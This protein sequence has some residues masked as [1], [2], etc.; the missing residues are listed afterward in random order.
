ML[1]CSNDAM[2]VRPASGASTPDA[3]PYADCFVPGA[4]GNPSFARGSIKYPDPELDVEGHPYLG[5]RLVLAHEMAHLVYNFD[6]LPKLLKGEN[7]TVR[8]KY[9]EEE[10]IYA[11]RFARSLILE[12]IAKRQ[13]CNS[14]GVGR[15]R[16]SLRGPR[17]W[18][19]MYAKM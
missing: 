3:A 7:P 13:F 17:L 6:N 19:I 18:S 12:P 11:W 8:Y 14:N 15:L 10:E 1:I 2:S 9:S 4:D 16:P 5:V